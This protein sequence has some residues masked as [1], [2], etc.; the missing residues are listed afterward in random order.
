ME[1]VI[2]RDLLHSP[3]QVYGDCSKST[4]AASSIY[5]REAKCITADITPKSRLFRISSTQSCLR[6]INLLITIPFTLPRERKTAKLLRRRQLSRALPNY[7]LQMQRGRVV[8]WSFRRRH[9]WFLGS[10]LT[11]GLQRLV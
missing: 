3:H 7:I 8:A 6:S 1:S 2:Y 5:P 10:G 11:V 4:A 9:A